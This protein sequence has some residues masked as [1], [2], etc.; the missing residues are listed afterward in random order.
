MKIKKIILTVLILALL[1]C[2][3]NGTDKNNAED[4]IVQ[5]DN[6]VINDEEKSDVIPLLNEQEE[7]KE[8]WYKI[9]GTYFIRFF[10]AI[11]LNIETPMYEIDGDET[12]LIKNLP[13]GTEIIILAKNNSG[14]D[15][16]YLV[17]TRDDTKLWSGWIQSRFINNDFNTY[18]DNIPYGEKYL[19]TL[20]E[21]VST[22]NDILVNHT[23]WGEFI[24]VRN[25]GEIIYRITN[26]EIMKIEPDAEN[27]SIIGWSKDKTKIWFECYIYAYTVCFGVID[28]NEKMYTI[29]ERPPFYGSRESVVDFETGD[30]Y[31]TDYPPQFDSENA[32]GTKRSG[33]V[34][35]LYS[36]NFYSMELHE[37]DTNIGE[38]FNIKYDQ[39]QGL[40]YEKSNYY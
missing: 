6:L 14:N 23:S 35:H 11:I 34:F 20:L 31:Y 40:I 33:T 19:Y 17:K 26:E 28:I 1:S 15:R 39:N 5:N 29:L 30:I 3:K 27:G 8:I 16:F 12:S 38:G 22:R 32:K 37:I 18:I 7:Q 21:G 10:N 24:A 4:E 13:A 25:T 36:Y 9:T 2:T